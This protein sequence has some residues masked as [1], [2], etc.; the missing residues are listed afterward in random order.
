MKIPSF[1]FFLILKSSNIISIR[2]SM[3]IIIIIGKSQLIFPRNCCNFTYYSAAFIAAI[4]IMFVGGKLCCFIV[5]SSSL[6][7]YLHYVLIKHG[8][9]LN[10]SISMLNLSIFNNVHNRTMENA[11]MSHCK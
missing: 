6:A 5:L 1:A 10:I 2:K 7:A 11:N 9:A 3:V 8:T 4:R